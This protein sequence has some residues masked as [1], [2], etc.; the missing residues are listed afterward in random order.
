M[1]LMYVI[2]DYIRKLKF[3]VSSVFKKT[4]KQTK[5]PYCHMS[6]TRGN[7]RY[8]ELLNVV[9]ELLPHHDDEELLSQFNEA[10]AWTAL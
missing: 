9:D 7:I 6:G 4:N 5:K 8:N 2:S 1:F 10:A 3:S